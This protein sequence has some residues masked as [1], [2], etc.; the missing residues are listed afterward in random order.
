[1]FRR[2]GDVFL[3]GTAMAEPLLQKCRIGTGGENRCY[4]A[5][6]RGKPGAE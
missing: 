1:M 3:L 5:K 6:W 4:R 2:D